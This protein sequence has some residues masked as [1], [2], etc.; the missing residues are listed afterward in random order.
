MIIIIRIM[1]GWMILPIR[2]FPVRGGSAYNAPAPQAR[3]APANACALPIVAQ[4]SFAWCPNDGK[5]RM[6][7]EITDAATLR[8]ALSELGADDINHHGRPL[9]AHLIGTYALLG[10]WG[11]PDFVALAPASARDVPRYQCTP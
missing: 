9:S 11:N 4:L 6:N 1:I 7:R 2:V 10:A 8:D 3:P 5:Q